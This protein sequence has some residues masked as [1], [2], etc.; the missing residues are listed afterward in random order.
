MGAVPDRNRIRKQF[1]DKPVVFIAVLS[2]H[3][4]KDVE[5]YAK[6]TG[7]EWPL[8]ADD[9]R[10]TE[11][12]YGLAISLQ[13]IY[14]FIYI[15][16]EG[17]KTPLGSNLAAALQ[18]IE[19]DLPKAKFF[20]DG[21]E[22]PEKLRPLTREI[23]LGRYDPFVGEIATVAKKGPKELQEAATLLWEKLK[24]IADS[25]V[26]QAAALE[27]EGKKYPAYKEYVRLLTRFKR[28]EYEPIATKAILALQK[29]K[30]VAS[31]LAA[32]ALLDQALG[33]LN[34][35]PENKVGAGNLIGI[36]LKKYPNTEAA[37][38]AQKL[39]K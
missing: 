25:M 35:K 3:P 19:R 36:L 13:N 8:L 31:E 20:F 12:A 23:E 39:P 6:S 4:L 2:G 7:L 34:A 1:I 16:P 5:A 11:K 30:E 27:K 17:K 15:D 38:E 10:R 29:Q 22:V 14:S 28:T 37:E 24:P 9:T 26:E 21:I 18:L 33:L 32:R